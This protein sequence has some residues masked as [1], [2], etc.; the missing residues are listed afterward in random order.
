M[1]VKSRETPSQYKGMKRW[2]VASRLKSR[3]VHTFY[4]SLFVK[5]LRDFIYTIIFFVRFAADNPVKNK[6]IFFASCMMF[7]L[8]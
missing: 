3:V 4:F 5:F 1:I 6:L 2:I 8:E 7:A